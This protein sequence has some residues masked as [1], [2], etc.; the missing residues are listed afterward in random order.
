V[1]VTVVLLLDADAPLAAALA[2]A[3]VAGAGAVDGAVVEATPPWCEHAPRPV[4]VLVVPS[5]H[6]AVVAV[7]VACAS[8]TPASTRPQTA[9]THTDAL[10]MIP[11]GEGPK[12][13]RPTRPSK[14]VQ[15]RRRT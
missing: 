6:V 12:L 13:P 14:L 10:R 3:A 8:A 9:T 7:P 4:V 11:P 15:A 2:F 5:L 1:H